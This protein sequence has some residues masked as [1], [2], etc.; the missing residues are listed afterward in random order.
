MKEIV[1]IGGPNGAG[2]TTA[3]RVL[4]PEFLRDHEFLNADEI[5][6]EISPDDPEAAALAAGRVL[7]ERMRWL[8]RESRSF[9]LETTCSGKSYLRLLDRCK[10]EG[11]RIALFYF[12]LPSPDASLARVAQRVREGGH[13]IP[14]DVIQ[15]RF[16]TGLWNMRNLYLPLADTAAIYDNSSQRR[17]LVAE[18]EPGLPLRV[19]DPARWSKMEELILWK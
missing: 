4:L 8:V 7:I 10:R 3:A 19:V 15:R 18:K 6:R 11:W 9:A 16:R 2:K 17:V 14:T 13:N 1:I 12:S 5:A